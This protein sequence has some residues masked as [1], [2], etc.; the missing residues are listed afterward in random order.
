MILKLQTGLRKV[1]VTL[2]WLRFCNVASQQRFDSPASLRLRGKL[3]SDR[4]I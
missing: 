1:L 4:A 2:M 3:L